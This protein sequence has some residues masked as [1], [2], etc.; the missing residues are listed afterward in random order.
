VDDGSKQKAIEFLRLVKEGMEPQTKAI[1]YLW[2]F[3]MHRN[4]TWW[5]LVPAAE[6]WGVWFQEEPES[7][8][9]VDSYEMDCQVDFTSK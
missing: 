9:S 4:S 2:S 5:V 7:F 3:Q 8:L 6:K 1:Y